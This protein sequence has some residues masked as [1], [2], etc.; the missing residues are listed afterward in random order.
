MDFALFFEMDTT[1]MSKNF[2]QMSIMGFQFYFV[3]TSK[4]IEL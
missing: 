2:D 1:Q 3:E 4:S